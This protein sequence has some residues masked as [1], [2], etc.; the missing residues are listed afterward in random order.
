MPSKLLQ[1]ISFDNDATTNRYPSQP[2]QEEEVT[3]AKPPR[4]VSLDNEDLKG[5]QPSQPIREKESPQKVP[6]KSVSFDNDATTNIKGKHPSQ[7]IQ[8][9]EFPPKVAAKPPR[10][11]TFANDVTTNLSPLFPREATVKVPHSEAIPLTE[12]FTEQYSNRLPLR[13][14]ILQ[15]YRGTIPEL[16]ISTSDVYN[17]H[18]TKHRS[19]VCIKDSMGQIYSVPINSSVQ[20]GLVYNPDG[21]STA[22]ST[23]LNVAD[24]LAQKTLPKIVCVT[25]TFDGAS[26]KSIVQK[27]ELLVI[28]KAHRSKMRRKGLEVH[29]LLTKSNKFLTGDCKG[30]FTTDPAKTCL[31]LPTIVDHIHDPFPNMVVL[32]PSKAFTSSAQEVSSSLFSGPVTMLYAKKETS[33][34]ATAVIDELESEARPLLDFPHDDC[35]SEVQV[36]ILDD[37]ESLYENTQS[38]YQNFDLSKLKSCKDTGSRDT[39]D[40]QEFFY[41]ACQEGF[42]KYG[43]ELLV[44]LDQYAEVRNHHGVDTVATSESGDSD[45]YEEV[46]NSDNSDYEVIKDPAAKSSDHSVVPPPLPKLKPP[47]RSTLSPPAPLSRA[48][49]AIPSDADDCEYDIPDVTRRHVDMPPIGP[50]QAA[51]LPNPTNAPHYALVRTQ[52][53]SAKYYDYTRSVR[54]SS[55]KDEVERNAI[56][57]EL[58]ELRSDITQLSSRVE[59]LE[60]YIGLSQLDITQLS[61]QFEQLEKYIGSSQLDTTHLSSRVEQLEKYSG[62]SK[63]T[64]VPQDNA[65]SNEEKN[66]NHLRALTHEQVI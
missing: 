7:P 31:H 3:P 24:I 39:Y 64:V 52:S 47:I 25:Q 35:L 14:I 49:V 20:F 2:I 41:T 63:S 17:I 10:S 53:A 8:E 38:L 12:L 28:L 45:N 9:E 6:V 33:L 21:R 19:V 37:C 43:V 5:R 40:T 55:S 22:Y 27:N 59:R 54:R 23:F 50:K 56:L 29:S 36:A 48:P 30:H 15:G 34:V 60:K 11:V 26:D 13:I 62:S 58:K 44:S 1:S 51:S 16:C 42:E 46:D 18:F 61:S 57:A 65:H 66:G 4:T 32:F